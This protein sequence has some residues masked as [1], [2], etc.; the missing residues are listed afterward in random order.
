MMHHL[1][2]QC[3]N[4][5]LQRLRATATHQS[6]T[7]L[8]GQEVSATYDVPQELILVINQTCN[9]DEEPDKF[10]VLF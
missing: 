3:S 5:L 9:A 6:M 7:E 4:H 2:S 1:F 10:K 8:S